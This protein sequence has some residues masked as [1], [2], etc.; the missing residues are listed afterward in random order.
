V[1]VSRLAILA[2]L[3]VGVA[4]ANASVF[5]FYPGNVQ[6]STVKPPIIFSLGDNAGKQ[7]LGNGNTITVTLGAANTSVSITVHP[8]YEITYYKNITVINNTD[9]Q[10]YYFCVNVADAFTDSKITQAKLLIYNGL[11]DDATLIK[12]VDLKTTTNGCTADT[13]IGAGANFRVDLLIQIDETGGSPDSA[14]S[15]SDTSA[16]FQLVYSPV[17]GEAAPAP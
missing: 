16:T 2:L 5:V 14:P 1:K 12:T 15:L 10:P 3:A 8:T 11:G 7:D 6:L 4:V 17:N 9:N 13:E